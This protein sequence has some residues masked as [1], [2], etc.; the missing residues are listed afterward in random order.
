MELKNGL[1]I[2]MPNSNLIFRNV[3]YY[4]VF[5]HPFQNR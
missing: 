3:I 4:V 2:T 1:K 5:C